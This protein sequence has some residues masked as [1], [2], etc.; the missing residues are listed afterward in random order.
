MD[1]VIRSRGRLAAF[2]VKSN[3]TALTAGLEAFRQRY[4]PATALIVGA[5]GMPLQEFF[6]VNPEE[7]LD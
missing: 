6:T 1:F 7:F 2:E 5:G 3:A 4:H